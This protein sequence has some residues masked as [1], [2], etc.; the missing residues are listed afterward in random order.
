VEVEI[1]HIPYAADAMEMGLFTMMCF[2]FAQ[3][4]LKKDRNAAYKLPKEWALVL[5]SS[6]VFLFH[7]G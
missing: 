1:M 7:E 4:E 5:F 2:V 6:C 3:Q